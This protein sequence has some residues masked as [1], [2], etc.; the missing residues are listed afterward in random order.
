MFKLKKNNIIP[1]KRNISKGTDFINT[2]LLLITYTCY[3]IDSFILVDTNF[4][5]IS[6]ICNFKYNRINGFHKLYIQVYRKLMFCLNLNLEI[7]QKWV[8]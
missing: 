5:A 4:R 6:N 3:T 7:L 1:R 8:H 2:Q